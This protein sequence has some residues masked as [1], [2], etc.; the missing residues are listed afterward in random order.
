MCRSRKAMKGNLPGV[1]IPHSAPYSEGLT[2]RF[3]KN[4][5]TGGFFSVSRALRSSG[6]K[7]KSFCSCKNLLCQLEKE[8]YFEYVGQMEILRLRSRW[9]KWNVENW[10][11]GDWSEKEKH[12]AWPVFFNC[13]IVVVYSFQNQ[14][15]LSCTSFC[16]SKFFQKQN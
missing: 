7:R 5:R 12:W 13:Q 1:Q 6:T 4:H 11:K 2:A 15:Q 3:I 8:F 9:H 16:F 10:N 14:Q